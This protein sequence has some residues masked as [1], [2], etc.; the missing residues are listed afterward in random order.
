MAGF[1][2]KALQDKGLT[3]NEPDRMFLQNMDFTNPK[4]L[5]R[6]A[7]LQ[8]T[9]ANEYH[10]VISKPMTYDGIAGAKKAVVELYGGG[11]AYYNKGMMLSDG[12]RIMAGDAAM[13]D[14]KGRSANSYQKT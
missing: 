8:K 12:D 6:L 13:R 9:Y 11:Y 10:E 2:D 14:N 3:A 7:D 4:H 5:M 1:M